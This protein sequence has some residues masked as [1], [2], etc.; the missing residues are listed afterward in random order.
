MMT[1]G[2]HVTFSSLLGASAFSQSLGCSPVSKAERPVY[3]GVSTG[4]T[5]DSFTRQN[6]VGRAKPAI[7]PTLR[8]GAA[9]TDLTIGTFNLENFNTENPNLTPEGKKRLV[10]QMLLQPLGK[11]N[12]KPADVW[13]LQEVHSKES[14]LQFMTE[15]GLLDEYPNVGYALPNIQ[16]K[17]F[18]SQQGLAIISKKGID[19]KRFRVI[20]DGAF[21]RPVI[22]TVLDV[23]DNHNVYLFNVHLKSTKPGLSKSE[24]A[25]LI[26]LNQIRDILNRPNLASKRK[27]ELA[28]DQLNQIR[29]TLNMCILETNKE[30]KSALKR[31]K[32]IHD[33]LQ[34]HDVEQGQSPENAWEQVKEIKRILNLVNLNPSTPQEAALARFKQIENIRDRIQEILRQNPNAEIILGGDFN[35]VKDSELDEIGKTLGEVGLSPIQ[36]PNVHYTQR[37]GRMLDFIFHRQGTALKP[38]GEGDIINDQG[39]RLSYTDKNGQKRCASDHFPLWAKFILSRNQASRTPENNSNRPPWVA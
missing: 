12:A 29:D 5:K 15:Q 7:L 35:L 24:E 21:P 20:R 9:K 31:L 38:T 34:H 23:G 25:A 37:G 6:N 8:F 33:L 10:K 11:E 1:I 18:N 32:E 28:L 4:Q 2:G 17:N 27:T 22:E 3:P 36:L 14:L 30:E 13:L 39:K 16:G 19:I 26:Q